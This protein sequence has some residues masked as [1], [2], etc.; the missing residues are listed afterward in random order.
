MQST[1]S[2]FG[3][4]LC[5]LLLLNIKNTNRANIYLTFY[6]GLINLFNIVIFSTTYSN[7]KYLGAIFLIHFQPLLVL[8]GPMLFFY[9]RGVINDEHKLS[10]RD[11]PH[12]IPAF[13]FLVNTFKYDFHS[14][15]EK[16]NFAQRVIQHRMLMLNFEP[17]LFSGAIAQIIRSILALS[18]T[19]ACVFMLFNY[20]KHSTKHQNQQNVIFRW[21][22]IL[23]IFDY[24]MNLNLFYS[25]IHLLYYWDYLNMATTPPFGPFIITVLA[26]I[27]TNAIVFFFPDILYGLPRMDYRVAPN[28]NIQLPDSELL[29]E[30][31]SLRD[32]EISA[33]KL[34]VIAQ[35]LEAYYAS[36]P[37]LDSKFNLNMVSTDTEIPI[38]HISYYYKIVLQTDFTTWKNNTRIAHAIDLIKLGESE[39][40]TLDAISK[41]SGFVSRSTFINCFKKVTGKTPSEYI[42]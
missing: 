2:I 37:Y 5:L 14:F 16:L 31:K 35:K 27:S 25:V 20:Y 21:F 34:D 15:Q 24:L 36:K 33:D 1:I 12:F 23:F 29:T 3:F 40:Y 32:F 9:V 39:N 7:N 8:I 13:L 19:T 22:T 10:K 28:S 6:I 18:Y 41:K 4:F 30:K 38:H 17:V 26:L 42:S 11:W